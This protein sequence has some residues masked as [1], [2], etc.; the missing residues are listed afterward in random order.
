[1][2]RAERAPAFQNCAGSTSGKINEQT[3]HQCYGE[4]RNARNAAVKRVY[5]VQA[6]PTEP[7][8][9]LLSAGHLED[10]ELAACT[11]GGVLSREQVA[12]F[13][14]GMAGQSSIDRNKASE[15]YDRRERGRAIV[16]RPKAP[17]AH[18][19]GS[20]R[21]TLLPGPPATRTLKAANGA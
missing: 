6:A 5:D 15:A 16:P 3:T 19:H 8:V 18:A 2:E 1:M 17:P 7:P 9:V 12:Q 21:A 11:P 4:I 10:S 20:R 14:V 13:S